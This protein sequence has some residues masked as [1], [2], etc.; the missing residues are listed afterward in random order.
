[1]AKV[2]LTIRV[3]KNRQCFANY[4]AHSKKDCGMFVWA[5][6]DE[7]GKPPWYEGYKG[8]ANVP[9]EHVSTT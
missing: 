9:L 8:N 5:E 3:R 4:Q 6:L 1:M 2:L 7:D